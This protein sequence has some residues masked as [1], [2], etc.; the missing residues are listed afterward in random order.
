MPSFFALFRIAGK[1][2]GNL[3]VA[4]GRVLVYPAEL[5]ALALEELDDL[6]QGIDRGGLGRRVVHEYIDILLAAHPALDVCDKLAGGYF[7]AA[8]VAAVDIPVEIAVA[9]RAGLRREL[10]HYALAV[11]AAYRVA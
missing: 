10:G 5:V 1:S 3:L 8:G 9:L 2:V 11:F 4:V 6:G 7:V